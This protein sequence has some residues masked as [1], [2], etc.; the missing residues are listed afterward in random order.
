MNNHRNKKYRPSHVSFAVRLSGI[1][2]SL[3]ILS[4]LTV[5]CNGKSDKSYDADALLKRSTP[6]DPYTSVT[7]E[8]VVSFDRAMEEDQVRSMLNDLYLKYIKVHFSA[9][10]KL[11]KFRGDIFPDSNHEVVL[12]VLG[13]D[14][15]EDDDYF[16]F[17]Q[18]CNQWAYYYKIKCDSIKIV[19]Q[20][21]QPYYF[22]TV[23]D[24][25]ETHIAKYEGAD[26]L[27]RQNHIVK[28]MVDLFRFDKLGKNHTHKFVRFQ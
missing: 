17:Q 28:I 26:E 5:S 6:D 16:R 8:G 11:G 10:N 7:I 13:D 19:N 4:A 27:A 12:F 23:S 14:I 3:V 15:R 24:F 25:L 1:I 2:I 22:T 18:F 9:E 20:D 21:N